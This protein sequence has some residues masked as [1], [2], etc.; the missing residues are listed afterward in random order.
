LRE[1]SAMRNRFTNTLVILFLASSLCVVSPGK[2][3]AEDKVKDPA[4]NMSAFTYRSIWDFL[5]TPFSAIDTATGMST[6]IKFNVVPPRGRILF[7][8]NRQGYPAVYMLYN[9]ALQEM[10]KNGKDGRWYSDGSRFICLPTGDDVKWDMAIV[11]NQGKLIRI[12]KPYENGTIYEASLCPKNTQLIYF[13]GRKNRFSREALYSLRLEDNKITQLSDSVI[14]SFAVSPDG[15]EIVF[16]ALKNEKDDTGQEYL[17][18]MKADGSNARKLTDT[19]GVL[20][21]AWSPSG[22]KIA[23]SSLG[24]ERKYRQ[25]F[26]MDADG[27]NAHQL[28]MSEFH[29]NN[30]CWSPDEKQ[31]CYE[32]YTHDSAFDASELFVINS[33]GTHEARVIYPMKTNLD[34]WPTES[35]PNWVKD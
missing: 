10:C 1:D 6:I 7:S 26:I 2:A 4:A 15:T 3:P 22:G 30:P 31:I 24:K 21:P 5:M 19:E 18:L 11:D 12:I 8:S 17:W 14:S 23:F 9:G 13:R 29:K 34:K 20:A 28:T 33:N 32:A 25:I 16:A 27:S 35:K